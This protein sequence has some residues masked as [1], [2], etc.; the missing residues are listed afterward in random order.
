MRRSPVCIRHRSLPGVCRQELSVDRSRSRQSPR[1]KIAPRAAR[2]TPT[3]TPATSVNRT[4][5][6]CGGTDTTFYKR[7]LVGATDERDQFIRCNE[8]GKL[9]YEIVSRTSRDARVGQFRPG[10]QFRDHAR[11]T[12]YVIQRVL[13]VGINEV[14]LYVKPILPG[15][16]EP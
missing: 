14:L 12:R 8:C 6:W 9:T 13:K 1:P 10:A 2:A 15:Q 4:C 11:Q 3:P 5:P 7:G 16:D